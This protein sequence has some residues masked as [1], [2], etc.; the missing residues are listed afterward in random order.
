MYDN[1]K[2]FDIDP[3]YFFSIP[4]SPHH[5]LLIAVLIRATKDLFHHSPKIRKEALDYFLDKRST[6]IFSFQNICLELGI[7]G[8]RLRIH[9]IKNR[10]NLFDSYLYNLVKG[11]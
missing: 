7:D 6:Y 2:K 11:K 8:Q 4:R 9:I 1:R 3:D 10:K 5:N